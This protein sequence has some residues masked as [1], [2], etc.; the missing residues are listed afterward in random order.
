[1]AIVEPTEEELDALQSGMVKP[2]DQA[3][4]PDP[5]PEILARAQQLVDQA[6][7][8]STV[9]VKET[10]QVTE[11]DKL[12]F[13]A[14][15]LGN[16]PYTKTFELLGGQFNLT[17]KTVEPSIISRIDFGVHSDKIRH[18]NCI[19]AASIDSIQVG[20]KKPARVKI[21][22]DTDDNFFAA[23]ET[24]MAETPQAQYQLIRKCYRSFRLQLR[25][26]LESAEDPDFWPT[27]SSQ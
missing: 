10:V 9:E 2:T 4:M 17:L 21:F 26:M 15:V 8:L 24:W 27:L 16:Q 20:N 25:T 18:Y 1:M 13:L 12:T 22:T 5:E 6:R 23:Y 7:G 11:K 19:M 3:P 14:H